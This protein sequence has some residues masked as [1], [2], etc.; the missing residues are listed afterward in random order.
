[1]ADCGG[2]STGPDPRLR[3]RPGTGSPED[4]PTR[5]FGWS[6][7]FVRPEDGPRSEGGF[8]D[9]RSTL[10]GYLRDYRLTIELKTGVGS[11]PG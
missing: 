1:M 11:R 9:E 3:R 7:M 6:N 2:M 10:T 4:G 5:S 8:S